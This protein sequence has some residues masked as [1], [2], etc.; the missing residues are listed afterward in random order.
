VTKF[1]QAG[2]LVLEAKLACIAKVFW[3]AR[4]EKL[5]CSLNSGTSCNRSLS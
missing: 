5:E 3:D 2:L 4:A 1:I